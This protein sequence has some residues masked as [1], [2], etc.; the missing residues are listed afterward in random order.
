MIRV[1]KILLWFPEHKANNTSANP[2]EISSDPVFCLTLLGIGPKHSK[3]QK[4]GSEEILAGL[5]VVL[6]ALCSGN[7][8][9][10]FFDTDH[11]A[12]SQKKSD[13]LKTDF[14]KVYG[15]KDTSRPLSSVNLPI[16]VAAPNPISSNMDSR[17]VFPT[18]TP[19][20]A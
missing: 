12:S 5:A 19:Y 7:Q 16:S 2:A 4:T 14:P 6:V 9:R 1:K 20:F 17:Y 3:R 18:K 11:L 8:R 10:I 13:G 15:S